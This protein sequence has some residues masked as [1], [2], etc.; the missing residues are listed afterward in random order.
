MLLTRSVIIQIATT[1]AVFFFFNKLC[2][3]RRVGRFGSEDYDDNNND[4]G[5]DD[6]RRRKERQRLH[7]V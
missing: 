7:R 4:D 3:N 1:K 5:D 2:F 6:K